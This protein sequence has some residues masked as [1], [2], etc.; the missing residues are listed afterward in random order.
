MPFYKDIEPT[1][2]LRHPSNKSNQFYPNDRKL[3]RPWVQEGTLLW[4]QFKHLS[5]AARAQ[6]K[7]YFTVIVGKKDEPSQR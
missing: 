6:Q 2:I 7:C 1:N 3:R 4:Q 5:P